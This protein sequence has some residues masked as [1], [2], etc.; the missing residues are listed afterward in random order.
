MLH[1]NRNTQNYSK[2]KHFVL[3][4]DIVL[5][6]GYFQED[7]TYVDGGDG[8]LNCWSPIG[9]FGSLYFSA[10]FDGKD[11]S[12]CGMYCSGAYASMFGIAQRAEIKNLKIKKTYVYNLE[13]GNCAGFV[14]LS[15]DTKIENCIF[16]G[17]VKGGDNV[18]FGGIVGQAQYDFSITNC[19]SYGSVSGG[20]QVAG[21]VGRV[22]NL[23][24]IKN[25]KN[26][27]KIVCSKY[28]AGG[29]G[30]Y[31]GGSS[32]TRV[33]NCQN[34]GIIKGKSSGGVVGSLNAATIYN[35]INY[36][37]IVG[38]GSNGGIIGETGHTAKVFNCTNYGNVKINSNLHLVGGIIGNALG[39]TTCA[40]CINYGNVT[41]L[42]L[43]GGGICGSVEGGSIVQ[44][45]S[46][47]GEINIRAWLGS[48]VGRL[49]EESSIK[50]C[51]NYGKVY[52]TSSTI[53]TKE[54]SNCT[55]K[56]CISVFKNGNDEIK[57]VY[58]QDFSIFAVKFKTGEIV[59]KKLAPTSLYMGQVSREYL[60]QKG[61]VIYS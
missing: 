3:T 34:F 49:M 6:D 33:E 27:C 58:A 5:N 18:A 13:S 45:C 57:E 60:V 53:A 21:I 37:A 16:D 28:Y 52:K 51:A 40:N 9:A 8:I 38:Y 26:F 25:C 22:Q 47:Y 15:L 1:N 4:N 19:E 36:E 39:K 11:F 44:Y 10:T 56:N 20:Q 12:I 48:V 54:N 43:Y 41:S 7:G 55:I 35:C 42:G 59:L 30:G 32:K 2:N 24:I 50:Y 61:F 14:G 31:I 46:N 23:G 17:V 29:I